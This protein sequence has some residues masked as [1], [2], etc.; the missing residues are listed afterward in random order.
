M[1]DGRYCFKT[2][3]RAGGKYRFI[4]TAEKAL[5]VANQDSEFPSGVDLHI[6][7]RHN[8]ASKVETD[9][10][11]A[12]TTLTYVKIHSVDGHDIQSWAERRQSPTV[13]PDVLKRARKRVE[14]SK[15]EEEAMKRRAP[16]EPPP[17][18]KSAKDAYEEGMQCLRRQVRLK[19]PK[20]SKSEIWLIRDALN[21]LKEA[22]GL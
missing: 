20:L 1:P 16:P 22:A 14:A 8:E 4:L 15:A 2:L 6:T 3:G 11:R 7:G 9:G 13:A 21:M 17:R 19:D 18:F 5:K 10:G 12:L